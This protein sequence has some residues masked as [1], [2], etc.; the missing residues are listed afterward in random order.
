MFHNRSAQPIPYLERPTV[1]IT[2]D[3]PAATELHTFLSENPDK[4]NQ[5]VFYAADVDCGTTGCVAGW[6]AA[7][8]G[9]KFVDRHA[10][11]NF[12]VHVTF[13]IN[14][15]DQPET[16]QI[17]RVSADYAVIA[18]TGRYIGPDDYAQRALGLTDS[19]AH[20]LFYESRTSGDALDYLWKLI[21]EA[22]EAQQKE[23]PT[24]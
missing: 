7:L 6:K 17:K 2:L 13:D 15:F 10:G 23:T 18:K 1:A 22:T 3:I 24:T 21:T 20:E 14:G 4:H 11:D 12:G 5:E 16:D 19:E 9:L 8:D